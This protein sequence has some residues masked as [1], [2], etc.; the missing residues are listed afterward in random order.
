MT[1]A[2]RLEKVIP[3]SPERVFRAW[4]EPE[5]LRQWLAPDGL[6]VDRLEIEGRVGGRLRV[7]H[8]DSQVDVGGFD[9]EILEL[10]PDQRLVFRWGFVGPARDHGPRYDSLLTVTLREAPGGATLLTL[11]H[12]RLEALAAAMPEVAANVSVGWEG[13]LR[14]LGVLL[15]KVK[16]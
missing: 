15:G 5:L 9:V 11:V 7:W 14:K 3:A 2:A 8:T 10:I 12:E 13:A 4:L 6:E 1:V 16:S